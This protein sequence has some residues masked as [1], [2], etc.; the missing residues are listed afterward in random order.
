MKRKIILALASA[1]LFLSGPSFAQVAGSTLLGIEATELRD[2]AL[3]WSA[4]KQVLGKKVFND[5]NEQIGKIDD[6][7]IGPDKSVSYA[8][9]GAGGFLGVAKHDIA[10]PV[11]KFRQVD[12]K[13]FLDGATRDALKAMPT[14]QYAS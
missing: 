6:V 5:S 9:I 7:I 8:I 3:G 10:I 11:S 13:F 14:F 4:R 1:A 12:G 2:V